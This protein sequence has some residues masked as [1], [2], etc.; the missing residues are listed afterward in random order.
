[1]LYQWD[2]MNLVTFPWFC[3]GFEQHTSSRSRKI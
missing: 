2:N 3:Y 1:M